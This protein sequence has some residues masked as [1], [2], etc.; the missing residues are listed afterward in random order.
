MEVE[1]VEGRGRAFPDPVGLLGTGVAIN[2]G[3][4]GHPLPALF[5]PTI[6]VPLRRAVGAKSQGRT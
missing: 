3:G 2:D 4:G 6:R 5:S 1:A